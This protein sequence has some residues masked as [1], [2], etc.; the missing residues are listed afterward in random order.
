MTP[1]PISVQSEDR[2][3]KYLELL[4]EAMQGD[5]FDHHA[6]CD[7]RLK[8]I[9]DHPYCDC[10]FDEFKNKLTSEILV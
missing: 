1:Q 9:A 3:S 10:G 2:T 5:Y 8:S 4:I 6:G 7:I